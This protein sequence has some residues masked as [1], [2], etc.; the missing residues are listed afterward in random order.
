MCLPVKVATVHDAAA[1]GHRMS[2]HIFCSRMRYNICAP[3][4]RTAVD[5]SCK[6]IIYNKWNTI[7]VCNPGKFFQIQHY[8]SRVCDRLTE[9]TLC[10]RADRL[11][12]LLFRRIRVN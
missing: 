12:D 6:R 2:I 1:D 3:L 10:V 9:D 5:R 7:S 8:Q 11:L 4:E